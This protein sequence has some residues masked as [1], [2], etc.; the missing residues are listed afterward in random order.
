MSSIKRRDVARDGPP[1]KRMNFYT[2]VLTRLGVVSGLT[3]TRKLECKPC[4]GL[5]RQRLEE[6][7]NSLRELGSDEKPDV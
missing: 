1:Q 6:L 4:V 7:K 5:S 3:L 2:E